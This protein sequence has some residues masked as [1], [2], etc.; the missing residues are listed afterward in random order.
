MLFRSHQRPA[1]SVES[2]VRLLDG[3]ETERYRQEGGKAGTAYRLTAW[4]RLRA[5]FF[6]PGPMSPMVLLPDE[7]YLGNDR[8]LVVVVSNRGIQI[9]LDLVWWIE[10]EP[11]WSFTRVQV[12]M[13]ANLVFPDR[14]GRSF[15]TRLVSHVPANRLSQ[16]TRAKLVPDL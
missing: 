14:C 15:V 13:W 8:S 1:D 7:A 16:G 12:N 4:E 6:L 11:S 2:E 10:S 3:N 5:V 9:P